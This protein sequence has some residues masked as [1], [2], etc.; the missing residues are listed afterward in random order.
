MKKLIVVL[1]FL[2]VISPLFAQNNRGELP[3]IYY[4]NVP[5]E[6]VYPSG[7]GYIVQYMKNT[8]KMATVGLPNEWFIYP[9]AANSQPDASTAAASLQYI[10]AG[11]AEIVILPPGKNWPTLTVFYKNGEFSHVRLYVHREKSHPTWGNVPQGADAGRYSKYFE[12]T[13]T[14]KIEY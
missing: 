13:D 8:G 14:I 5:V 10:A 12:S 9:K 11:R 3:D 7:K 4:I 2:A 1:I 6:K